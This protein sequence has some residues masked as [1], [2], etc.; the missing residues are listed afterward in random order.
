MPLTT[1]LAF[2]ALG[3]EMD[4]Q[5]VLDKMAA[6]LAKPDSVTGVMWQQFGDQKQKQTFKIMR[7][8]YVATLSEGFEMW[9]QGRKTY[10]FFRDMNQYQEHEIPASSADWKAGPG[11]LSGF[12]AILND[13]AQ[14]MKA[15]PGPA[16]KV[17][18]EGKQADVVVRQR[19]APGK[20]C[21]ELQLYQGLGRAPDAAQMLR[22]QHACDGVIPVIAQCALEVA[23]HGMI[24]LGHLVDRQ[25]L[26]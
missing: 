5:A 4:G 6:N 15:R 11:M 19:V 23:D 16:K 7:P 17:E 2:V 3:Q 12:N 9:Q 10:V 21:G 8:H 24:H 1:F 25:L 18:F 26:A 14:T 22:E 20:L 13:G